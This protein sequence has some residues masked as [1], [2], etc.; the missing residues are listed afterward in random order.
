LFWIRR[1]A[2]WPSAWFRFPPLH[3]I[4][5]FDTGH[6]LLACVLGYACR[7]PFSAQLAT[8]IPSPIE[9]FLLETLDQFLGFWVL[10]MHWN[11]WFGIHRENGHCTRTTPGLEPQ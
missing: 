9:G 3:V 11:D 6:V 7:P 8:P 5:M 10:Q 1:R 4:F 2:I